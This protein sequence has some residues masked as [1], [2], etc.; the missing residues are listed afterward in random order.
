MAT[1]SVKDIL[2]TEVPKP[3]FVLSPSVPAPLPSGVTVTRNGQDN[4]ARTLDPYSG[5]FKQ[6]AEDTPRVYGS[7][8][9]LLVEADSRTNYVQYSS[10]LSKWNSVDTALTAVDNLID[11]PNATA[12]SINA[13]NGD[14]NANAITDAGTFSGGEEIYKVL[15]GENTSDR[16]QLRVRD[17]TDSN[18]IFVQY[19]FSSDSFDGTGDSQ[20]KDANA[21]K[22]GSINGSKVTE[23]TIRYDGFPQGNSRSVYIY[24]DRDG[25][26]DS[27]YFYHAQLEEAP[28]AS[29]PIVTSGSAKTRAGDD[30]TIS[31]GDWWNTTQGS[32][33]LTGTSRVFAAG[34]TFGNPAQRWLNHGANTARLHYNNG[35]LRLF[36]DSGSNVDVLDATTAF[37]PV[38]VGIS[39]TQ[40]EMRL[41]ANG[42][43]N[44]TNSH[45]G[46]W[47]KK[48]SGILLGLLAV[49]VTFQDLSYIPR[50]L[51]E[52]TLNTLTR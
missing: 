34:N 49:S 42:S 50:A 13:Q 1:Q 44:V 32:F 5:K 16:I 47:L 31:V 30:Y 19:N 14:P 20:I 46:S 11:S 38:S 40:N 10:D 23:I 39:F 24:P 18:S 33:L 52:S 51:S 48:P 8:Q 28:N 36:D 43:S 9:G 27:V 17:N 25:N 2:D 35:N 3:S 37:S 41:S 26:S 15:I 45:D 7:D 22:F 6:V 21:R 29:S 12:H 4:V